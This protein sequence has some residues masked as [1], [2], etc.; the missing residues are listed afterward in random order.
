MTSTPRPLQIRVCIFYPANIDT[1]GFA[2]EEKTKPAETREIEGTAGIVTAESAAQC[3]VD[4]LGGGKYAIT[5]DPMCEMLRVS[6]NGM[7]PRANVALE[8]LLSPLLVLVQ[9]GFT[10]FMDFVVRSHGKKKQKEKAA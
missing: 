8:L 5:N 4:G 9:L 6:V 2:E 7:T 3:L 10:A 1:P